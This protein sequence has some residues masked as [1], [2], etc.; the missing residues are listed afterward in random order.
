MLPKKQ[1]LQSSV[2]SSQQLNGQNYQAEK[3]NKNADTIDAVHITY[4]FILWPVWIFFP[5]VE[6]FRYLFPDSHIYNTKI[7]CN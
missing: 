6:I 4:P 2:F 3:K 5:Q 1:L 7:T